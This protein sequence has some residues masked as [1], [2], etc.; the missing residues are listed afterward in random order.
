MKALRIEQTEVTRERLLALAKQI[1]GAWIGLK[2]AALLLVLEGQH[3][4]WISALFG[5]S[6]MTL[7]NWIHGVNQEGV[8][9]IIPDRQPGR[10]TQ[11]TPAVR[12][13]L[14]RDLEKPPREFGLNRASWDG[15]TLMVHLKKHFGL[16]LQVRQAQYWLHSLDYSLKRA[17]YVYLQARAK[18]ARRFRQELKKTPPT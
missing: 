15:P 16:K 6:R 5:L 2:I 3:P 10:P 1:P 11:L 12:K 7:V 18:D 4:G 17:G 9:A 14:E 8:Q 13:R